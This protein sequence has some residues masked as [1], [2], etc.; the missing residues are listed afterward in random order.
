MDVQRSLKEVDALESRATTIRIR[1]T[2]ARENRHIAA[3]RAIVSSIREPNQAR[4]H[5]RSPPPRLF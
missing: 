3:R 4:D 1:R 5:H 2:G